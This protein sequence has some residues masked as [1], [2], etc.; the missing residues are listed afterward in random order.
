MGFVPE[1]VVRW[2]KY[3][4]GE[5]VASYVAVSRADPVSNTILSAPTAFPVNQ[6][7]KLSRFVSLF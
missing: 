5:R 2:L 3:S 6:A 1:N 7:K 4:V